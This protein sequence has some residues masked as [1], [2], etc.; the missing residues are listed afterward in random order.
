M[1]RAC[2]TIASLLFLILLHLPC[3]AQDVVS[4]KIIDRKT[5]KPV[6]FANIVAEDGRNGT[7]SDI[8]GR[9][10]IK[11]S[12][13]QRLTVTCIGYKTTTAD[14]VENMTVEMSQTTVKLDEITINANNDPVFR[15]I[16]SV[17]A[18]FDSNNPDKLSSYSYTL[19]DQMLFTL[20]TNRVK[21]ITTNPSGSFDLDRFVEGIDLFAVETVSEVEFKSPNSKHQTVLGNRIAGMKE[22]VYMYFFSELQSADLYKNE[23]TIL[24]AKHVNPITKTG[25]KYYFFW[26]EESV[27]ANETDSV[28]TIFFKPLRS[29]NI[30]GVTGV[31]QVN[32]DNWAVQNISLTPYGTSYEGGFT[33]N[34]IYEKTE[35]GVWFPKQ[36]N[37]NIIIIT[38][39]VAFDVNGYNATLT[40]VGRSFVTNLQTNNDIDKNKFSHVAVDFKEDFSQ[41]DDQFWTYYRYDT[42]SGER[43]DAIYKT[44]DSI[45]DEANISLDDVM[46]FSQN[47]INSLSVPVGKFNID[48]DRCLNYSVTRGLYVGLGASTNS[49][50]SKRWSFS[51]FYGWQFNYKI[52]DKPF[53]KYSFEPRYTFI[54]KYN[55]QVSF[56]YY[57]QTAPIDYSYE[58]AS[59]D[60]FAT[61]LKNLLIDFPLVSKGVS[62]EVSSQLSKHLHARVYVNTARKDIDK[63]YNFDVSETSY[64]VAELGVNLRLAFNEKFALSNTGLSKI[65]G[66][67]L[68]VI[69]LGYQRGLKDF[70]NGDYSYNKFKVQIQYI[71]TSQYI[72]K[73]S[74]LVNAG[75]AT[76]DIPVTDKFGIP[77]VA[78]L[79]RTGWY[80]P[81]L[82]YYCP[83]TFITMRS[84]EFTCDRFATLFFAHNF[85]NHLFSFKRFKPEPIIITN[86]GWGDNRTL[87]S[88]SKTIDINIKD[89]DKGYFE[90]GIMIDNLLN[91]GVRIGAGVFV[92]YGP[93]AY[94][95]TWQNV[96]WMLSFSVPGL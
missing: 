77:G 96:S 28:F 52:G 20:D 85:Q 64:N 15:I 47:L 90:S 6:P 17:V 71:H 46:F 94:D 93:Y 12:N 32:S 48:L 86:I 22:P 58:F 21:S 7:I 45:T 89:M 24:G 87:P 57:K 50:F 74:I 56:R 73:T 42:L 36:L 5:R 14:I 51:G 16:D 18:H 92:R 80:V 3:F 88:T 9:F 63:Y 66:T 62:V 31:M 2:L 23:I 38:D 81:F 10:T 83:E 61:T 70:L 8:D 44:I 19:Y 30:K 75:S 84:N 60:L 1:R 4:G 91:L 79:N 39:L 35:E 29:S 67:R 55:S 53:A 65:E 95:K 13:S 34:Q 27:K 82:Y 78:Y 76:G 72:G 54:P 59:A 68:P 41:K 69:W 11:K 43:L 25:S 49:R 37:F 26:L 33:V 40:G